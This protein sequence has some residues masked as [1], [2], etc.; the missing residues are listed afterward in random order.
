ML[1]LTRDFPFLSLLSYL[2]FYCPKRKWGQ[3][4]NIKYAGFKVVHC[5]G[6]STA[7]L[8]VG[9]HYAALLPGRGI[10]VLSAHPVV[11]VQLQL[12]KSSRGLLP[13]WEFTLRDCCAIMATIRVCV[14]CCRHPNVS[15]LCFQFV[16][17]MDK[18]YFQNSYCRIGGV[19]NE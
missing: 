3:L 5:P 11:K 19:K 18:I 7:L 10:F 8:P 2:C 1:V 13:T 12:R 9:A 6:I 17:R 4:P 14:F 15:N 16:W